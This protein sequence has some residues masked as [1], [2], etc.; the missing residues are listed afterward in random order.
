[1]DAHDIHQSFHFIENH[2]L[3]YRYVQ[4][5]R[6]S[7]VTCKLLEDSPRLVD[8]ELDYPRYYYLCAHNGSEL[9]T[10]ACS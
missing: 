7:L 6:N 10:N 1:M 5:Y 9:S 3:G 4:R 8:Y 2:V